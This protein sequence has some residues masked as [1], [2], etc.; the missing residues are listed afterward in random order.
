MQLGQ[1]N[2]SLGWSKHLS[3]NNVAL[4]IKLK[5][6]SDVQQLFLWQF[7]IPRTRAD[8]FKD[9]GLKFP[10]GQNVTSM[11]WKSEIYPYGCPHLIKIK[12]KE[13]LCRRLPLE[14]APGST[15]VGWNRN[16]RSWNSSD[17]TI[18]PSNISGKCMSTNI[19]ITPRAF[20]QI[21][22]SGHVHFTQASLPFFRC[23]ISIQ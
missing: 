17:V 9:L 14:T 1:L 21:P 18:S 2:L 5:F 13:K 22:A 3:I 7:H 4:H 8:V 23:F 19:W 20:T 11:I 10:T 15:C 6:T 12:F 16:G